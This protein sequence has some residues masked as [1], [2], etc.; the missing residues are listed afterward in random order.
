[1]DRVRHAGLVRPTEPAR[2]P[3]VLSREEVRS[4]LAAMHG[5]S[6]LVAMLLNGAGLRLT[7]ALELR[8]RD[9]DFDRAQIV[10]RRGKGRKDRQTML[11]ARS[12]RRS[13]MPT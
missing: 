10:V 12:W 7:E 2:L 1:M 3:V 5:T 4:L 13:S 8:V 11:S 6:K 9:I